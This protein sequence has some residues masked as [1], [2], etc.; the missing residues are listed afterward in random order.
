MAVRLFFVGVL[1]LLCRGPA[2]AAEQGQLDASP[3]LFAVLAAINAAGYD[4]EID[5]PSG[6]PLR[7]SVRRELAAKDIPCLGELKR[8]FRDHRQQDPTAELSQYISFALVTDGPPSF[9]PRLKQ[10]EAPPDVMALEG[11]Q[12][13]MERFYREA[14]IEALWQKAQPALDAALA[15]YQAPVV[16]AVSKASG[17]LRTPPGGDLGWRFQVYVD[18]LGAPNQIQARSYGREYFVV[19]TPSPEPQAMDVR[20]GYLHFLLD[21]LVTRR[22]EEIM[23]KKALG[24]YA[25]GAPFLEEPYRSDFLLLANECL[26]KAVESRLQPGTAQQKLAVVKQALG[27]GWILTPHFAEQLQLFEAEDRSMRLFFPDMISSINL[28]KEEQRLEKVE[29]AAEKSVRTVKVV[30]A[31]RQIE[32]SGPQKSLQE[33]EQLYTAHDLA[34]AK[35]AFLRLLQQTSESA[36]QGRAFYGLARIAALEKD[37]GSAEKL[38]QRTL[39]AAPDPQTTAWAHVYLGRLADLAGERDKAAEHYKAASAIGGASA[40]AREAA[41]KGLQDAFKKE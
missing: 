24:E 36:M 1:L 34:K 11:L 14:D 32:L 4:A 2:R 33:A 29:F 40:A 9:Q 39:E 8:F 17:Y 21:P 31:E 30:P 5:S 25:L 10:N 20:H 16:Q 26:I 6:H 27:E 38:F 18:L 41:R 23:K 13:L 7:E 3:S 19:V 28:K 15:R 12:S 22:S 37:P 35:A